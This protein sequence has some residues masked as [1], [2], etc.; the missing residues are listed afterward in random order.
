M[1]HGSCGGKSETGEKCIG[2]KC[3]NS[4]GRRQWRSRALG[5]I[6]GGLTQ[7]WEFFRFDHVYSLSQEV[8]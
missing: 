6:Q 2:K 5:G 4:T 1:I 7:T 8:T 3:L